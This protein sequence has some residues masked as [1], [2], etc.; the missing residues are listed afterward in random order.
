MGE[1]I[2]LPQTPQGTAEEQMRQMYSYLYR[3]AEALNHNLS[4]IGSMD[5]TDE[6]RI[7]MQQITAEDEGTA[8]AA[9]DWQGK[10]SLKSLII[11][12]AEF[13]QNRLDSY[14]LNLLGEYVTEGKFGRYVRNTTL[15]VDVT[16]T[17]I[18]QDY[19]FEEAVQG[20]QNYKINSKNYIKT[21]LLRTV[22]SVPVYGVAI[23]KDIV[24]FSQDGTETYNDG[25]KVAELTSDELSFW[26]GGNKIASYTGSR[27]SFYYGGN[28]CFYIENGK[29]YCEND[30]E[31]ASGKNLIID[32]TNF[33]I[34]SSGDVTINGSGSLSG[35]LTANDWT[36]DTD[37]LVYKTAGEA[38]G[39]E[40][41]RIANRSFNT[42][43]I[44]TDYTESGGYTHS[45]IQIAP[46]IKV[47]N[48]FSRVY[49]Q[50]G[51]GTDGQGNNVKYLQ[52]AA[53]V[54]SRIGTPSR[55]WDEGYIDEINYVTLVQQSSRDVKHGIRE[56]GPQGDRIDRLRPVTFIYD[57]DP[58][59]KERM[60]LI[61]EEAQE[62]MPEICTGDETA[63]GINYMELVPALIKEIQEL[64]ARVKALEERS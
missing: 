20:V 17:G 26:Q 1:R 59:E 41:A 37:G 46:A 48:Q 60:G 18:R 10:E 32:S 9:F 19:T 40:I 55:H 62:V 56:L 25:N 29:I 33:K 53:G 3:V 30:L 45:V 5:L 8:A 64:R 35:T 21:G 52:P 15:K 54:S 58:K 63:K 2:E 23:G 12:T 16:P 34:N 22:S 24:T 28:V 14:R 39:F 43:G 4:E 36:L 11:K 61:Y 6:E 7:I 49:F 47:N 44:Y 42:S 27:I 13:V 38:I 57:S 51:I 50:F 31:L